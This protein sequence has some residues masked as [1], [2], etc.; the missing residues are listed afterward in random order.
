MKS[1]APS[2]QSPLICLDEACLSSKWQIVF[3]FAQ[4]WLPMGKCSNFLLR[5]TVCEGGALPVLLH[6]YIHFTFIRE[7]R[8]LWEKDSYQQRA[9]WAERNTK[10]MF[11]FSSDSERKCSIFHLINEE[12]KILQTYYSFLC[13]NTIHKSSF[14]RLM[15]L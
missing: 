12:L 10:N 2:P 6:R 1:L 8:V 13:L 4:H 14:I 11:N 3:Q 5:Q 7:I 9:E 15:C